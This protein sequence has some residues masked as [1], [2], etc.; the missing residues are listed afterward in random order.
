MSKNKLSVRQIAFRTL[1]MLIAI[2]LVCWFFPHN[3][4]FRYEYEVGKPWRY[5]RLTAPYDFAIYR[6]D[7]AV[8][9]MEDSLRHQIMPRFLVKDEVSF[10]ALRNLHTA[11]TQMSGEA[12][13]HLRRKLESMYKKGILIGEEKEKWLNEGCNDVILHSRDTSITVALYTIKSEL[14]AYEALKTDSLYSHSYSY[15]GLRVRQNVTSQQVNNDV[16][17]YSCSS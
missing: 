8:H 11:S 3:E 16:H 7:S 10:E 6:S 1:F 5:G 2:L 9:M 13:R 12:F 14:E 15:A 4:A 17:R